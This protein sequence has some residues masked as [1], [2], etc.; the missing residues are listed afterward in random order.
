MLLA[1]R[2]SGEWLLRDSKEAGVVVKMTGQ[3]AR[4]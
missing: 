3:V 4:G 1:K 2:W